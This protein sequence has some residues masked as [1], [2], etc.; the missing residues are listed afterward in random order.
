MSKIIATNIRNSS[1]IMLLSSL[2]KD[3]LREFARFIGSSFFNGRKEAA[4]YFYLIRKFYPSFENKHFTAENIFIKMY[5]GKKF[6]AQ[7]IRRL[8]SYLLKLLE[9]YLSYKG[10]KSDRFYFDLT[11]SIQLSERGLIKQSQKQLER[12]DK[13][14]SGIAGDYEF[15]FWKRYL[16]ERHRNTLYSYS[17]ND[18]LATEAILKRTDMFAFHAAVVICK[19]LISLFISE[20]NFGAK[21]SSGA[22]YSFTRCLDLEGY[23]KALEAENSNYYP[24]IAAE[25]YQ[26]MS[27]L[28]PESDDFFNKFKKVIEAG[29]DK[30]SYIE[31]INFYTIFEAVCTLKIEKGE[32]KYSKELFG[33]YMQMLKE[34][35]YSYTP[36]G[37]FILRIFRNI[38]HMAVLQKQYDWLEMFINDYTLK[39]PV[40]SQRN[41]QNLADALLFFEK[42]QFGESLNKL[43]R[44]DYQLFHYKIDIKNL[45]LKLYY[46]LEYYEELI[47]AVDSYRHFIL[48]NKYISQR[49]R[50]LCS[51]FVNFLIKLNKL[52]TDEYSSENCR[53][54]KN[55][56]EASKGYL[57]KQWLLEKADAL[58]IQI[59]KNKKGRS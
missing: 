4:E 53:F 30:F 27:L 10:L 31:K 9:D 23:L 32:Q 35:L 7:A 17:G 3:E 11:L 15:Y 46:E 28:K 25:Y 43:N 55:E 39:L 6:N 13:K 44:I 37:E 50:M 47:S 42:G 49:Y 59:D 12:T 5:P 33:A 45:Q 51:G 20:K 56:I 21:Y 24:V 36:G 18:H 19:S 26:A 29:L 38:V 41:M 2:K 40:D 8:N 14:Y 57:F 58:I 22:F 52:R 16:I 1:A 34:G 48:N 54:I